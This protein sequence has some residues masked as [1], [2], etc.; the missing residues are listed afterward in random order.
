MVTK[1]DNAAGYDGE[2]PISAID[3]YAFKL[4]QVAKAEGVNGSYSSFEGLEEG[5]KATYIAEATV[6]LGKNTLFRYLG[7]LYNQDTGTTIASVVYGGETYTWQPKPNTTDQ[8]LRASNWR[9]LN[10]QNT[11]LASKINFGSDIN[12]TIVDGNENSIDVTFVIQ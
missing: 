8:Y 2:E 5:V 4:A 1:E 3:Y 10:D 6:G 9:L 7:A 11:T 12:F